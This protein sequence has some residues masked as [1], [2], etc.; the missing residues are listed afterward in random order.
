MKNM[1]PNRR[2]NTRRLNPTGF[3]PEAFRLA[4]GPGYQTAVTA[5]V[6]ATA[7]RW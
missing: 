1:T 7:C 5:N 3:D 2:R 6:I 4:V